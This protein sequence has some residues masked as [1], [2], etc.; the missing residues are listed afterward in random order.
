VDLTANLLYF[1][2]RL[3]EFPSRIVPRPPT[4][5]RAALIRT[6][7]SPTRSTSR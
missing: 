5:P 3:D 1:F 4:Q 6:G 7:T 2:F